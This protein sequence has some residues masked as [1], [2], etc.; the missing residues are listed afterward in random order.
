VNQS[1]STAPRLLRP[2]R[3]GRPNRRRRLSPDVFS[4]AADIDKALAAIGQ[5]L[6]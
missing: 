1:R 5:E 4:T 2:Q 3:V 6:G